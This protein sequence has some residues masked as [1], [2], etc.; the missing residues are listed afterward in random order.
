MSLNVIGA[1]FGRTGTTSLRLALNQLNLGPTQHMAYVHEDENLVNKFNAIKKGASPDWDT[2]LVGYHSAVD[3]PW[4]LYY[5]EIMEHY[6]EAKV[7]LT[8]RDPEKWHESV[9]ETIYR[10]SEQVPPGPVRDMVYD[11]IWDGKFGGR[12]EDKEHAIAVF[13][14]HIEEVKN[15]VPKERLL[16]FEVA[17]GWEP[18]CSFLGVPVPDAPF[19]RANDRETFTVPKAE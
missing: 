9:K 13:K 15:I 5:K 8:V 4:A 7:V 1:G 12:F 19:P 17:Q 18:L 2:L 16:V 14:K 6:P 11:L 10:V 3:F